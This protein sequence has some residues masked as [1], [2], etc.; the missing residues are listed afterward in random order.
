MKVSARI[1]L[2][3]IL[4]LQ[5]CDVDSTNKVVDAGDVDALFANA[6]IFDKKVVRF[7]SCLHV[8]QHGMHLQSCSARPELPLVSFKPPSG[9]ANRA[10]YDRLRAAGDHQFWEA[11]DSLTSVTITGEFQYRPNTMPKYVVFVLE[12]ADVTLIDDPSRRNGR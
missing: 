4:L 11:Q 8:S 5:A 7:R 3:A 10:G 1:G 2:V 6:R 9:A 12:V